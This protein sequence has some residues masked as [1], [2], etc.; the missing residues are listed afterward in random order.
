MDELITWILEEGRDSDDLGAIL[1]GL[2]E[3]LVARGIP[4]YRTNLSMPTI[5]PEAALLRFN[6][7]RDEGLTT[8]ALSPEAAQG[9]SFRRSPLLHMLKRNVFRE[10]WNLEDPQVVQRF[11]LFEELRAAGVT[12]YAI[13]WVPFS[14]GRTALKGAMLTMATDRPGGFTDGQFEAVDR[15]VPALSVVAYRIGLSHVAVETLGAYLGP[16]TAD[17]VLQGMIRRGDS[18]VISAALLLA[19]LRGFTA[20]VDRMPGAEVV[21]WLNQHLECVGDAITERGGE[22]LKFLGDGLLAVVPSERG[23]AERACH[24]ALSAAVD[25]GGRN[26]ALN[27]RRATEGG[28]AL[29]LSIALHFGDVIYGNIGTARRLDFT[30]VGPAVNEVSR[31]ET[32]GKALGRALLL[33]QSLAHRCGQ[34]VLSLGPHKLR[35]TTGMREMFALAP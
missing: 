25:A 31:M 13:R 17:H 12:E 24:E 33:S 1:K 7:L 10:R 27:A 29:D 28:P 14:K 11:A 2:S 4:L 23:G 21:G 5:D 19:D 20:L 15:V 34:P 35:G 3:R 32:L 26:A 22:V 8:A 18:Q 6:W 9:A 16:Q 30:V